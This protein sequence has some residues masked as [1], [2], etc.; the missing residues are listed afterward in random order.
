MLSIPALAAQNQNAPTIT[1][2]YWYEGVQIVEFTYP[3]VIDG[4]F[5]GIAGG[6]GLKRNTKQSANIAADRSILYS[7]MPILLPPNPNLSPSHLCKHL[8]LPHFPVSQT[9][10]QKPSTFH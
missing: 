6:Y 10:S 3:I 5:K 8:I 7:V 2:P 4:Q 9:V 1:E